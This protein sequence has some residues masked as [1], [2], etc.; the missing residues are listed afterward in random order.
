MSNMNDV[1]QQIY[2]NLQQKIWPHNNQFVGRDSQKEKAIEHVFWAVRRFIT[3]I[4]K[5]DLRDKQWT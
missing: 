5:L 1:K 4:D 3:W 2:N